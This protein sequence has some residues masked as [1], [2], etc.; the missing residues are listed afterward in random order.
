MF[1]TGVV[2]SYNSE[3]GF[4]F[5]TVDGKKDDIFFHIRDYPNRNVEPYIG[6][7]LQFKMVQD[8]GKVKADHITRLDLKIENVTQR[9]S[10]RTQANKYNQRSKQNKNEGSSGLF[11]TVI[12]L[13]VI[14]V[15]A[16]MLYGKYQRAQLAKQE[17]ISVIQQ[18]IEKPIDSNP[19]GYVCDG[20]THCS[21]MNSRTEARWFVRN[22]PGTKMD[23][24]NDG[25][26]CENDSRW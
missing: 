7:K 8:R 10:H 1:L 26:P 25:E 20:R 3:R 2:K 19:N 21:Q 11:G 16:Y 23:G 4:G 22:C 12:G 5:I 13:V 9:T 6:E 14:V 18:V 17:P 15:L 24:N